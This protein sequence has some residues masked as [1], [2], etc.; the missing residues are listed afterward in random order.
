M[1]DLA[2]A[3]KILDWIPR[4]QQK[5]VKKEH[6]A[7]AFIKLAWKENLSHIGTLH[8]P[9]DMRT[10]TAQGQQRFDPV[11][12]GREVR[13]QVT[14]CGATAV[15]GKQRVHAR[16]AESSGATGLAF[17]TSPFPNQALQRRCK[18]LSGI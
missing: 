18:L 16:R 7:E 6:L 13:A 14:G 4:K 3:C 11:L 10:N 1:V 8:S 15:P 2:S 5:K 17:C 12:I 9:H